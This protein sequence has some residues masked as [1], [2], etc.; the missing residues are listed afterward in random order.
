MSKRIETKTILAV[1]AIIVIVGGLIFKKRKQEEAEGCVFL[2][3]FCSVVFCSLLPLLTLNA[4]TFSVKIT[5]PVWAIQSYDSYQAREYKTDEDCMALAIELSARNMQKGTGGPFGAAIFERSS[6][7]TL[8]LYAIGTNR[9]TELNNSTLHGEMMAIQFAQ[10]KRNNYTLKAQDGFPKY[11]LFTSCSPCIQCLGAC[12]WSGISRL[13]CGA[14]KDDAEAI[15]FDEGPVFEASYEHL[16]ETGIQTQFECL[17][18]QA[19]K[20]LQDYAKSGVIY[21]P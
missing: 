17:R 16:R 9:V 14:T 18:E 2:L 5:L 7:G 19:N 21:N 20:V 3:L 15:G 13:V 8:S 6:D 4:T 12:F 10:K 1:T 11:E